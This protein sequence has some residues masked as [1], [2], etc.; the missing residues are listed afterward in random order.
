LSGA[1]LPTVLKSKLREKF[2]AIK[3][4]F[5]SVD[6]ARKAREAKEAGDKVK[7]FVDANPTA[8]FYVDVV[9]NSGNAKALGQA[10]NVLRGGQVAGLVVAVDE[11]SGKVSYQSIVP[12]V[13][14]YSN[15]CRN[16]LKGVLMLILGPKY[17]LIVLMERWVGMIYRVKDLDLVVSKRSKMAWTWP[18]HLLKR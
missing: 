5:D 1:V 3:K 15:T 16:L 13:S 11:S 7:T 9:N 2:D 14:N 10:V 12:K 8:K 17:L 18:R 6:K 4:D